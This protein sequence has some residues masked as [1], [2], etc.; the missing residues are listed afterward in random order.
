MLT[1][2]G[3]RWRCPASGAG[4]CQRQ[5]RVPRRVPAS[6][7]P[8]LGAW[9]RQNFSALADKQPVAP[10]VFSFDVDVDVLGTIVTLR[11]TVDNLKARRAAE[12]NAKNTAGVSLVKNR[13]KVRPAT[14]LSDSEIEKDIRDALLRDPYVERF[15]VTVSVYNGTAHL[16]GTVDS[17]FEKGRADDVT[18]RVPGV[19]D[20]ENHLTVLYDN[21][22]I[23]D[24]YV[25]DAEDAYFDEDEPIGYK[26]RIPY[27]TDKEI[28]DAVE[29][30]LWWSP[31]VDSD[32]VTVSVDNG[33]VTL[34]GTVGS[35]N[36]SRAATENA[37]EGG[38]T[39]VDN[40][41]M[42]QFN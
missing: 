26:R 22:Y 32:S 21:A 25:D 38:A 24:P 39:L 29:S 11:G 23:F 41:L 20:V 18:A 31:F 2:Y 5:L 15:D 17:Y 34:T 3:P 1:L 8:R 35:W 16:Y 14:P 9:P 6:G 40:D 42:V 30:Q 13:L 4:R 12:Q 33:V 19:I 10:G 27:R 28:K 7:R 36:E 37:Y